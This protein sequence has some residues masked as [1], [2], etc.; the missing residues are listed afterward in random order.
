VIKDRAEGMA[1]I[2]LQ[3]KTFSLSSSCGVCEEKIAEVGKRNEVKN[4]N[5]ERENNRKT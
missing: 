4:G 3:K 5:A 1:K 2:Q